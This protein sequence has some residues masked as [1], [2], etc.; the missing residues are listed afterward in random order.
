MHTLA[1]RARARRNL[2]R[3]DATI[4]TQILNKLEELCENCDS[5]LTRLS[6][7]GIEGSLVYVSMITDLQL[8]PSD[9]GYTNI[10]PNS[11]QRECSTT[12][13]NP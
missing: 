7:D 13:R 1:F 10:V 11:Y 2:R 12:H 8:R 9:G 5:A 6:E 3:L 4:Q